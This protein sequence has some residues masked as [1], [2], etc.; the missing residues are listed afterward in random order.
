MIKKF[1]VFLFAF[2]SLTNKSFSNEFIVV[3]GAAIGNID[4]Q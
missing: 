3:I 4:N 1:I 2:I